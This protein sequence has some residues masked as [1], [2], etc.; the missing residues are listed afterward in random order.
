MGDLYNDMA[1]SHPK[2]QQG[3]VY[4]HTCG[5]EE[6]VSSAACLQHGWPKCCGSTMSLDHPSER[7]GQRVR[8]GYDLDA[9]CMCGGE[10]RLRD[11]DNCM[12]DVLVPDGQGETDGE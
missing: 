6:D 4:C 2:L 11:C 3:K 12:R 9:E 5:R 8:D 7:S 1:N 10:A